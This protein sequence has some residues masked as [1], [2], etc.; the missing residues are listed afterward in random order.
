MGAGIQRWSRDENAV[1]LP[2]PVRAIPDNACVSG[3]SGKRSPPTSLHLDPLGMHPGTA[4]VARRSLRN[5]ACC[6][7]AGRHAILGADE[8]PE[9]E[10]ARGAA[11]KRSVRRHGNRRRLERRAVRDPG[12]RVARVRAGNA[13]RTAGDVQAARRAA[14]PL[15]APLERHRRAPARG[16]GVAARPGLRLASSRPGPARPA[17]LRPDTR[18]HTRRHAGL[19]E[20]R[21]RA[22]LRAAPTARLSRLRARRSCTLSVGAVLA[23]LERAEQTTVAAADAGRDLCPAPAQ[24]RL[25]GDPRRPA[26]RPRRRRR[27]GTPRGLGGIAPVTWIRGMAAAHAK[28]DAYA[29]HPYPLRPGETPSSGGCRNCPSITMATIPKLL[30]LV[31]RAFGPKPVWLTEYGYQTNPPDTFLGVPPQRQATLLSLAAMRAWRLP[32]VTMLIQYL[33]RDEAALAR[34][35]TGLVFADDRLKPSLQGFELPFAELRRDGFRT[36][37]WGQIRGGA[38]GRKPYQLEVLHRER[39]AAGR[40][41]P[42]DELDGRLRPDDSPQARRPAPHLVAAPSPLQPAAAGQV[43]RRGGPR[44]HRGRAGASGVQPGA[45]GSSGGRGSPAGSPPSRSP[46]GAKST[47]V[48][49]RAP[50]G[51][52]ARRLPVRRADRRGARAPR[53]QR[54]PAERG[55]HPVVDRLRRG[56]DTTRCSTCS[57]STASQPAGTPWD[58]AAQAAALVDAGT[59]RVEFGTPQ[60]RT[61]EK[62]VGLLCDRV[63]P[64]LPAG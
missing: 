25:R 16:S 4:P 27:D 45:S 10:P 42:A 8:E 52:P 12:R 64:A 31:R 55:G 61:T 29:H 21:A 23:D 15:H 44:A 38:P 26:T 43:N 11:C 17:Q 9:G 37:V 3:A 14:R 24:P 35:Q 47:R 53:D 32:R 7:P 28:L 48:L 33:Y 36:V 49:P 13:R 54:R 59:F 46:S 30:I 51:A 63:L 34:F 50:V 20:R 58:V 1:G 18:A 39:V 5:G 22:Q 2:P 62:G 57:G 40:S 19:G 60:G 41:P 6:G 56:G